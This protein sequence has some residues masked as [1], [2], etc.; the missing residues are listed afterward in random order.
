MDEIVTVVTE[1]W[2]PA[3][4]SRPTTMQFT[5]SDDY[6]RVKVSWRADAFSGSL[7]A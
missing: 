4:P 5:G 7:Q 3:D 6:L 2:N 1:S